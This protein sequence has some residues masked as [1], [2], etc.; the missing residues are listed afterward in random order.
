MDCFIVPYSDDTSQVEC[1]DTIV[2]IVTKRIWSEESKHVLNLN[3]VQN[4][5]RNTPTSVVLVLS[6]MDVDD[7]APF[8]NSLFVF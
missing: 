8:N 5:F 6:I 7:T 4:T 2:C 3:T 1:I